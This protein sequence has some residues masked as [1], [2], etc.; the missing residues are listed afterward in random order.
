VPRK[1]LHMD[2]DAFFC[3]VEELKDPSL[4]GKPFAVGGRPEDRGV[5]AS[6]SYAARRFGVHSAMPMARALRLCPELRLVSSRHGIYGEVSQRVMQHLQ[7]LTALV[8]QIS[9]DEA[10]MDVSDL[11]ETGEKIA[12]QLQET[13]HTKE[14]LPSSIGVATNKLV[15]KIANNMGKI[16]NKGVGPPNAITVVPAGEEA[17]FLAPLPVEALWGVGPK[18]AERLEEVN[19][20]TIGDLAAYRAT[21]LARWFGK[22]GYDLSQ[23]AK[24]IDDSPIITSR[25][26]KSV[27]QEVTFSQDVRDEQALLHTIRDLSEGVGLRLRK[28]KLTASTVK[29]K[30]RWPD[31]TTLT[32]Q[33]TMQSPTDQ[34]KQ[35]YS[36]ALQLFYKTWQKGNAVRLIG[37]GVSG[38]N[39]PL[40][41]LSLWDQAPDSS[42]KKSR[43]LQEAMD[44]LRERFGDQILKHGSDL[45]SK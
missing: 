33:T 40:R 8:E 19:I 23:C 15:A 1:I 41:Q 12:R 5:V 16:S 39:T 29:L 31:F 3:A 7:N 45:D 35:I 27:S 22:N 26:A 21:D 37:V 36:T 4:A 2:L 24:G 43:Q 42:S 17:A 30:L 14:S 13:I 38:L 32:R 20:Y 11:P 25:E 18:T 10:F 34:D 44:K 9:I 6:C 28:G